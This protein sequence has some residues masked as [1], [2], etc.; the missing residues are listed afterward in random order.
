M[1][2][3]TNFRNAFVE[4]R[5]EIHG[6][7][8]AVDGTIEIHIGRTTASRANAEAACARAAGAARRAWARH[9]D[10][11]TDSKGRPVNPCERW[12]LSLDPS[13]EALSET[14]ILA[15]LDSAIGHAANERDYPL[16]REKRWMP[17]P[18][19]GLLR[20]PGDVT[21]RIPRPDWS[22]RTQTIVAVFGG[23]VAAV[24][25][26]L[27][28]VSI[29]TSGDTSPSGASTPSPNGPSHPSP[30]PVPHGAPFEESVGVANLTQQDR[31]YR[32]A[33]LAGAGDEV[34]FQIYCRNMSVQ[35]PLAGVVLD[36][37][38]VRLNAQT[39]AL[40]VQFTGS[41]GPYLDTATVKA[42]E[43]G[44]SLTLSTNAVDRPTLRIPSE[45]GTIV[46]LDIGRSTRRLT[47]PV[48]TARPIGKDAV[49]LTV[50]A[51]VHLNTDS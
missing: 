1:E 9:G 15:A 42:N 10:E 32:P 48:M 49:T 24:V 27:I 7:T 30:K 46:D 44:R 23:I 31:R 29:K 50:Y 6:V 34:E 11:S 5:R 21:G 8:E 17:R 47:L 37:T 16:A 12:R 2:A 4:V 13:N 28:T 41:V 51:D 39:A 18:L 36:L 38:F 19:A 33:V 25:G 45:R 40:Q 35:Q 3:L 14:D 20:M 43:F 26:A 22:G